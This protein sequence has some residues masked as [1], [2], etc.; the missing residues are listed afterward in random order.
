MTEKDK[1]KIAG[2]ER[3]EHEESTELD[4][5]LFDL[6]DSLARG[7]SSLVIDDITEQSDSADDEAIDISLDEPEAEIDLFDDD[8]TEVS[9]YASNLGNT[10]LGPEDATVVTIASGNDATAVY[11]PKDT[12]SST[13]T[14]PGI[15][16]KV[17]DLLKDR[18]RLEKMLGEGGMGA[19]FLAVDQRKIEARHPDPYVAIKLISGD[20]SQ[21]PL[22]YISLQRET[23]KSQKLAHP[24]VITVYDFDR[25]GDVFFM[26]MEA[27]KGQ[28]LD[29][30]IRDQARTNMQSVELINAMSQGL[31][32]AHK[33][34]IV[35][36]D[37]KPQNIFVT[38][39]G[40]LKVLDFGIARALAAV[41]GAV[42]D[43]I[44]EVVG[45]TPAYASCDMFEGADPDPADDVYAIGIIAYQLFT[46]KHPFDRK[47][48]TVARDAGMQPKRIKGIPHY[49]WKAI[50]KALNFERTMRW[51][52]ADQFYR[53]FSGAGRMAKHLSLA[54]LA[55]VLA[56]A[57]YLSFYTPEAGPDIPFEELAPDIQ[58][59]VLDNL[60]EADQALR[61]ADMN[62]A[63]FYLDRAYSLHPRNREVMTKI[64]ALVEKVVAALAVGDTESGR[65]LRLQQLEELMK[66]DSLAQNSELLDLKKSLAE[67]LK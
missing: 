21:D 43:E 59:K 15:V 57:G 29:D 63:L 7:D 11:N 16:F 26:T 48:A 17:G 24:N 5:S 20:F 18:F 36:S 12:Q 67:P 38:E 3:A 61:F 22:A 2:V 49:Q 56:F 4:E 53:Q 47:K 14:G 41:D 44:D 32:Y 50:A 58:K 25:D 10:N 39:A 45:L 66:Y 51:Q 34:N 1:T 60:S 13:R 62:G 55:V 65:K 54:L 52:N 27:L 23:D 8:A 35:H 9:V 33:R 64:D 40:V 19:V 6:E 46:G 28:T 37:V 42:P 30:L 31:A